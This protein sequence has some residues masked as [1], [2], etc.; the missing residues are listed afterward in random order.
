MEH[1]NDL[2]DLVRQAIREE[3]V[4]AAFVGQWIERLDPYMDDLCRMLN[5]TPSHASLT[6]LDELVTA[7]IDM[8]KGR[9]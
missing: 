8:V 6:A 3:R 4:A 9:E 1:P 2:V 7:M 5:L